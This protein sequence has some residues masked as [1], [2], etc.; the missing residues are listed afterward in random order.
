MWLQ[1]FYFVGYVDLSE[2]PSKNIDRPAQ[3]NSTSSDFINLSEHGFSTRVRCPLLLT[4]ET[5]DV[6]NQSPEILKS[7]VETVVDELR[8]TMLLGAPAG[9]LWNLSIPLFRTKATEGSEFGGS[10]F[11]EAETLHL[12]VRNTRIDYQENQNVRCLIVELDH[13]LLEGT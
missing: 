12:L 1:A 11:K 6:F 7:R 8:R 9:D 5:W 13:S 10:K 3:E 4:R 2:K